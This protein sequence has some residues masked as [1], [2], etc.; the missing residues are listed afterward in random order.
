MNHDK[1]ELDKFMEYMNKIH[2]TIKFTY[3]SSTS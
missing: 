1:D 2:D 3:G